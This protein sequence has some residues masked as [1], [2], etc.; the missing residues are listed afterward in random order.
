MAAL[1]KGVP[2]D[3]VRMMTYMFMGLCAGIAGILVS[4]RTGTG[5]I[6]VGSGQ[7]MNVIASCVIGGIPLSGG[8]GKPLNALWGAL[9][10]GIIG[11]IINL[12]ANI[13]FLLQGCITGGIMVVILLAQS[14]MAKN[15][16]LFGAS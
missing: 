6:S 9:I 11:N 10:I 7:E 5:Q 2:V 12:N 3:R 16:K 13:S 8:E 1:M 15:R 14:M 4:T